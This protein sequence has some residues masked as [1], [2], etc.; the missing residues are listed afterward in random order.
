MMMIAPWDIAPCSV[1]EVDR[2]FRDAYCPH[3][4]DDGGSTSTR[5]HGAVSQTAAIFIQ[6]FHLHSLHQFIL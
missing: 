2:R 4:Q 3:Y 6:F 5:L 1:V